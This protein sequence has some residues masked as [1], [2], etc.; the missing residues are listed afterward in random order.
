MKS[1]DDWSYAVCLTT[2]PEELCD[3]DGAHR[4]DEDGDDCN[5][6]DAVPLCDELHQADG[7]GHEPTRRP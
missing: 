7:G 1:L 3:P 5:C 6:H 4:Q 2:T